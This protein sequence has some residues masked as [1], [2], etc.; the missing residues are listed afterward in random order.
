M[1]LD[2][3]VFQAPYD[4]DEDG[5]GPH[6]KYYKSEKILGKLYRAVDERKIWY[7]DVRSRPGGGASFWD[8]FVRSCI[9]RCNAIGPI[10]WTHRAEQAKRIRSA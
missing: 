5:S 7:E 6:R 8:E 2:Q 3:F 9:R 10:M 1:E 4:E